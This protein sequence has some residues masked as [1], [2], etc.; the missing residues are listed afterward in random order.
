MSFGE[1]PHVAAGQGPE[2]LLLLADAE[3]VPSLAQHFRVLAPKQAPSEV[4]Q[5]EDFL[6][7]QAGEAPV[8]VVADAAAAHTA[9]WLAVRAPERVRRLV[10]TRPGCLDDKLVQHLNEIDAETLVVLDTAA[11]PEAGQVLQQRIP[12][13][14]R[15][16]VYSPA[17]L[18]SL[19][20]DFLMRGE[21]FIVNTGEAASWSK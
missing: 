8:Y 20:A 17:R 12:R 5:L 1:L 11:Q 19:I 2:T 15:F 14:Y 6:R 18:G 7:A 9:C 16:F 10:L 13:A 3:L 4:E 21:R